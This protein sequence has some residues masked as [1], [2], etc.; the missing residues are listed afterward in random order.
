MKIT[1][2]FSL[3]RRVWRPSKPTRV[4]DSWNKR[5]DSGPCGGRDL[6]DLAQGALGVARIRGAGQNAVESYAPGSEPSGQP[7]PLRPRR[8]AQGGST[9]LS[10]PPTTLSPPPGA[11]AAH[12]PSGRLVPS[13][14]TLRLVSDRGRERPDSRAT[15]F[16]RGDIYSPEAATQESGASETPFQY[17]SGSCARPGGLAG[18]RLQGFCLFVCFLNLPFQLLGFN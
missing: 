13:P 6:R 18:W 7:G 4:R 5:S 3:T 16:C 11:S 1:N 2:P 9:T 10:P 17:L 8:R 15:A 14:R 12:L